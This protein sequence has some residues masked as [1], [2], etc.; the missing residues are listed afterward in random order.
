MS[1]SQPACYRL[2]LEDMEPAH[3]IAWALDVP[4]CY[5]S[6]RTLEEAVANAPAAIAAYFAWR[7]EQDC[8][9]PTPSGA[10]ETQVEETFQAFAAKDAPD[11]IVNAFF[12]D[13]RR[14]LTGWEIQNAL[15]VLDWTR[16]D[17][18]AVMGAMRPEQRSKP[19]AR[20]AGRETPADLLRHI[21]DAENWY[22][23]QLGLALGKELIPVDPPERLAAV[24]AN[25]RAQLRLLAGEAR[26][27]VAHAEQWSARKVVRRTLWHERDHTQQ[28]A[29][30]LKSP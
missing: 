24:R 19:D 30:M 10:I 1:I 14:P 3:W 17:L 16:R 25:S 27:T 4:G 7:S 11:T 23:S 13:D 26:I 20:P 5:S 6:A 15:Q 9:F 29:R 22:F 12:E 28:I 2:A 8:S 18:D 21:A